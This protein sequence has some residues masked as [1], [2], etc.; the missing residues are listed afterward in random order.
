MI[1]L[2]PLVSAICEKLPTVRAIYSFGSVAA[3]TDGPQ[4]DIDI[5]ILPSSKLDAVERWEMRCTLSRLMNRDVDL[6]DLSQVSTVMR[7]QVVGTGKRIYSQNTLE[8][9]KF[10]DLTY[11]T[12]LRFN[13]ERKGILAEIQKRGRIYE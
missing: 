10:D 13:E 1:N 12:Y 6:V 5:A 11:S 8:S 4:S 9:E 3:G 7:F 2:A